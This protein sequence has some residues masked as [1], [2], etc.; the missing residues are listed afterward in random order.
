MIVKKH[1]QSLLLTLVALLIGVQQALAV[2]PSILNRADSQKMEQWVESTYLKLSPQERIA[3]IMIMAISPNRVD[4][5]KMLIERYVDNYKVGGLIF[6]SSDIATQANIT[7]YAQSMSSIPLMIALDAEWGLTMRMKDAPPFPRNL[8]LGGI[9]DDKLLYEYGK[10][11]ARECQLMGVHVNFAPVLDVLDR[12]GSVLGSR[13]FGYSPEVVARH[14]VAFAKGLEDGGV[15]STAKH[16]PGHGSTTADSHKELPLINKS[17]KEMRMYDLVPFDSYVNAGLG[18]ILTA[19][20]DVSFFDDGTTPCS[21]SRDCV[22]GLLK[23]DLGFEG[24]V[25]TDALDMEGAKSIPGDPSVNAILAGNDV[26][27][28]PRDIESSINAVMAAIDEGTISWLDIET[29]CKKMLRFKYAL[30]IIDNAKTPIDVNKVASQINTQYAQDLNR[31]LIA[32]AVTVA[33]NNDNV[34]PIKD[35]TNGKIQVLSLGVGEMFENRCSKYAKI[36]SCSTSSAVDN[37]QLIIAIGNED[38]IYEALDA[39]KRCKNVTVVVLDSPDKVQHYADLVTDKHVDAVLF[40]YGNDEVWQDYAAQTVFAGNPADG[41]L[42]VTIKSR[43]NNKVLRAGEGE[44]YAATRLGYTLPVEVGFNEN[45]ITK[46]D[47]VCNYGI[48]QKA[49][50]G[51]QVMVVRHGKVVVDRSYGEINF[52]S[53]I[54]VTDNT[55]YGLASVSKATGTLSGI[56]KL[57]DEG[58]IKLDERASKYIVG[59]RDTDKSDLTFRQLL[60]HETGMQPSLSMWEMMF[61]PTTYSGDLITKTPNEI[62]TIKV[63]KNAYGN[64][65]AKLRI[66]I[67]ASEPSREFN[68]AIAD[69]IYGGKVTYDSIMTRI[70]HSKLRPNKNYC[71][72]CLN[73]CL[74]ADALQNVTHTQLDAYVDKNIFSKLGAYHTTYRPL[75]K[76]APDDIAYTEVDTY[77]RKQHIHGYVHD[78]L[79]AFSGGV[80]GNAG[81]FSN[82]NDLAK[83]FQMWLNGGEYGGTTY[84]KKSTVDTFL[85]SKSPNSHRGLGFDKP[86]LKDKEASSTCD[87]ATAETVGHTGFT[88]TCYWIDPKNDMIYIFLSNRVCPTRDNPAFSRVS[89]RSHINTLLYQSIV[90]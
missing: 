27:L 80:Q 87:E 73:F 22:D 35:V 23:H 46:I 38:Y 58:K 24:L 13:S 70:Y 52:D 59:L 30:G 47:S 48:S 79:A 10:E 81:L 61:D 16:F 40:G 42:P 51:C 31:R 1:H 20:I 82:A 67:L 15:L 17:F 55:L 43:A 33:V 12:E 11:V 53:G 78:E 63:M 41:V 89:A 49:F 50:P 57:Y 39:A 76:F 66:D 37:G 34:L 21:M 85:K 44:K 74:L 18:G 29:R 8:F 77:L 75:N 90:E 56:M 19:H 7:N 4:E 62:N 32:A 64:K 2:R 68:I 86:N 9:N 45:L 83:L 54:P 60:Y 6:E 25:F 72:S 14:G 36:K 65:D 88:G 69:G 28:M 71:Y 5:S 26:L 3:Q 84:Y